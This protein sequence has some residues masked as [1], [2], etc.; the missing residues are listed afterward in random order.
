MELRPACPTDDEDGI[1]K[2]A[3]VGILW[4]GLRAGILGIL[5]LVQEY[6]RPR[7]SDILGLGL[8]IF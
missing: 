5:G 2:S 1:N 7:V 4:L 3:F 6:S 8:R